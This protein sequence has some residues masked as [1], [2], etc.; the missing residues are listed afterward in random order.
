MRTPM[1]KQ[2]TVLVVDDNDALLDSV[3]LSLKYFGDYTVVV[4]HD[5][6][7]GLE[8]IMDLQPDCAVI[9][10]VMPGLNGL[11]LVRAIRGD[12]DTANIPLVIL[13]ALAQP[14][15]ELSGMLSGV[16]QYLTKPLNP[17]ALVAAIDAALTLT[18][19]DRI[20]K[21]TE[22]FRDTLPSA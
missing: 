19:D 4:A 17:Q 12:P 16:D 13:S 2:K 9:D 11:Q 21:T 1:A 10:V 22:L 8:M 3:K 15:D 18:P 5:G 14:E 7:E 6:V 20:K